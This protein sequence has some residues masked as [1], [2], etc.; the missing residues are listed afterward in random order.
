MRASI[1][2]AS[3]SNPGH[4]ANLVRLWAVSLV[5]KLV[6]GAADSLICM[7]HS[8]SIVWDLQAGEGARR[9]TGHG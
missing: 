6:W 2:P 5:A 3:I 8:S 4:R 1:E 7:T 9:G